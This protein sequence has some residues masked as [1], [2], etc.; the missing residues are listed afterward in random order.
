MPFIRHGRRAA[1]RAL[2]FGIACFGLFLACW[3]SEGSAPSH[4]R[5]PSEITVEVT[6]IAPEPFADIAPLSGQLEA[7]FSV[8]IKPEID[9]V[10]EAIAFLEGQSVT[11]GHVLFQLRS[12]EQRARLREAQAELAL[13]QSVYA[14]TRE[15]ADRKVSSAAQQERAV[16]EREI[17]R[18]RVE[19][20]SIE[21][22][23]TEIRAP[24]DG[25]IGARLVSPGDR[26][27]PDDAL[28]Q[29]DA[30]ER[31]QVVFTLSE[32]YVA[33][34]RTGVPVSV[35]VVAYP[36]QRFPGEVFYVSP[37]LDAT[38]RRVILKAWV[39]NSD[40]RLRAGMFA[41]VEV[42]VG[43]REDAILVSEA[44]IVYDRK[45]T[46]VWRIGADDRAQRVSVGL[47]LRS[48]GRV[49]VERGLAPGDVVVVA[50]TH[51]LKEG[52]RIRR[53]QTEPS[54][55]ARE[56]REHEPAIGGGT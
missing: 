55:Q 27:E 13:A 52:S 9:G 10:V 37:S 49:H 21:V 32:R 7:E 51:K 4:G 38:A 25:V 39:P 29:I 22:Q 30:I 12:D 31:L 15:L 54:T 14:R 6:T 17:A 11:Q 42:E 53:A 5:G 35:R 43:R 45:G 33:Q 24:F 56:R 8:L 23:R 3:G 48:A 44:A 20:A 47:G 18:A 28:V 1:P 16:A 40:R 26:V 50:G 19:L 46:Y 34:T 41:D 2:G 36:E